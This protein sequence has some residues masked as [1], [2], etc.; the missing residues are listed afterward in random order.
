MSFSRELER[1]R[2]I[3]RRLAPLPLA[4]VRAKVYRF[5]GT[6]A[7]TPMTLWPLQ[8]QALAEALEARGLFAPLAVGMGKTLI[9]AL[10][11]TV[12]DAHRAV[13]LTSAGLVVQAKTM[14]EQYRKSFDIRKDIHW[15]S[16]GL[17]SSSKSSTILEKINPTLIISDEAQNLASG[18]SARVKRFIRYMK[19]HP[20]T[21]FC[22]MSG[23]ITKRSLRDYEHLLR[24]ALKTRS[25]LP[26]PPAEPARSRPA[27]RHRT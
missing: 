6:E 1:I 23:S 12:L 16:Y 22:A 9:A 8:E 27:A 3:P 17:L 24:L 10:I 7:D 15:L 25:P 2:A 4:E 21:L 5:T 14:M 20:E 26:R 13:I 18:S 19:A 11:P